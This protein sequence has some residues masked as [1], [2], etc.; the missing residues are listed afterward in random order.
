MA[1]QQY[2]GEIHGMIRETGRKFVEQ[3][4]LPYI[5]E[6]EEK[7]EFPRDL[8]RKAGKAGL[9]GIGYPEELGGT[10][11]DVFQK[12]VWLEELMRAGSGGLTAGLGSLDISQPP[13][14]K[15]ARQELKEKVVPQVLSGE[16]ISALAI[17]EPGCG[18]DVASLKTRAVRED[19]YYRVNGS[20]TFITSGA[21][22]DYYVV[23]VRT[24]DAGYGGV[25]LL[26]IERDT[27]G[28]AIGKK[29]DKMGWWV[30]DTAELFFEDCRVPVENLIGEENQGESDMAVSSIKLDW[31]MG[32]HLLTAQTSYAKYDYFDI[33]DCDFS[34][35]PF[36]QVHGTE[37]YK[38]WS[39]EIRLTS[40]ASESV[41]YIAGIYYHQSDLYY[42]SDESFGTA[43]LGAPNVTRSY[44]FDQEQEMWAIFGSLTWNFTD[45]TRGTLGLRYSEEEKEA[46]HNL[47]KRFTGNVSF[48]GPFSYGNTAAEY[49][50]FATDLPAASA[51]LDANLWSLLGTTE[52]NIARTRKEDHVSWSL[53]IEHDLDDDIMLYASVATGFKG[54]GFDGRYLG[55][56]SGGAFEYEEEEAMNYELGAKMTLLDGAATLNA[57]VFRTDVE[58][59]QVSVFDGSTSFLVTNA[60][61]LR[62]E[63]V[64]VDARWR[65]T[66][67]LMINAAMTYLDNRWQAWDTAPCT[68]PQ[69]VAGVIDCSQGQNLAGRPNTFSPEWAY[70]LMFDYSQPV[71]NTLEFRS[72]LT[73]NFS[74][75][76][77]TA[78]DLDPE[79]LQ[80]D[81]TKVD[82][83]L[84]IG[85]QS[86]RWELAVVGKNLTNEMVSNNSVDQPLVTGNYFAITDRLRSVAIQ[87]TYRF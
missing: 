64:E 84:S 77:Y 23:A 57:T 47:D 30:S 72:V 51:G 27:P 11:G 80:D 14:V 15:F 18:S 48:G 13:L 54:G 5:D 12:V 41:E 36:I 52:H 76:Y 67:N 53:N 25:S 55:D 34:A 75:E 83:R 44:Q 21:R 70:N 33:C 85:D 31:S 19:G 69:S 71:F 49:D 29:L 32:D 59:F 45:N 8:Y 79:S 73:F 10:G 40:L 58:D 22:A 28:F 66:E 62:V 60:A 20:K 1:Y 81:F 26:L 9:L 78:P 68:A 16:K 6:W 17:T 24:G 2:F 63:G 56:N 82:L 43:V 7:G 37:D 86:Q 65:A 42:T 35:L 46:T 4:V 3:E 74:D 50:R 61:E 87:G 39:Q 38:Q